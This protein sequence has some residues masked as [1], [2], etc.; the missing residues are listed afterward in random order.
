MI[1][2]FGLIL[3]FGMAFGYV[4][5]KLRLPS[6]IGMVLAGLILG[7]NFCNFLDQNTLLI[8]KDLRTIALII[9]LI[10]A[11]LSLDMSDLK[12]VGRPASLL[13][14]LPA[15]FEILA[16]AFFAPKI[17]GIDTENS[18]LMGSVIAAVSP[19][20]VVPRMVSLIDEGYGKEKSIPQ[21][22]LAGASCDDVFVLVLFTSFLTMVRGEGFSYISLLRVPLSILSGI[23]FGILV[24]FTLAKIFDKIRLDHTYK[25]IFI[26]AISFIIYMSEKILP[27]SGLIAVITMAIAFKHKREAKEVSKLS[28]SFARIW[29]LA[30]IFLFVLLGAE[31][32]I[33]YMTKIGLSGL[34]LIGIGLLIRSI[35][36]IISLLGTGLSIRE[37][38]FVIFSYLPKA[39]VQAS[40][41]SVALS[42]G[43]SSGMAILSM[44]VLSI[45]VSAPLGAV[46][47]DRTY[48]RLLNG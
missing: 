34:I 1:L 38:I 27:I 47:I 43:L 23:A 15:S 39:T 32:D 11:G 24:G 42:L 16:Y 17:L 30:E 26:L 3:I 40:I 28:E 48:K 36:V 20:I 46:L 45:L 5:N 22:V 21:M 13:A 9:I 35:G 41:G 37:R 31:V 29:S 44:A 25:L 2:S 8:S 12:K 7:P 6:V 19:A 14:F 4:F 18:L 10:K 33:S